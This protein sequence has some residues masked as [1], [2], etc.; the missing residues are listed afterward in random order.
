MSAASATFC[1]LPFSHL[2]VNND[3]TVSPCCVSDARYAADDGR[4]FMV[5]R[6]RLASVWQGTAIQELRAA[7]AGGQK[8]EACRTCWEREDRG[9]DSHRLQQLRNARLSSTVIDPRDPIATP[10]PTFITVRVGSICNLK[11]R[12][13]S[14]GQSTRWVEEASAH[15]GS[16][17]ADGEQQRLWQLGNHVQRRR[18]HRWGED[19]P[20]FWSE[21][22]SAMDH[23]LELQFHGGEPFMVPHQIAAVRRLSQHARAGQVHL[24]YVTNGTHMPSD[25]ITEIFPRFHQVH[26]AFS[27]DGTGPQFEYQRHGADWHTVDANLR[28]CMSAWNTPHGPRGQLTITLT[29]S[30][31]NIMY[32]HQYLP[33]FTEIG[34]PVSLNMVEDRP[35]LDPQNLPWSLRRHLLDILQG[36]PA[37]LLHCISPGGT[38]WSGIC[39]LLRGEPRAESCQPFVDSMRR[40]DTYRGENYAAVF[41]EMARLVGYRA[42]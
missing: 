26:V 21:L 15:L 1:P 33:Y 29:V 25:L 5:D 12:I 3:G 41:P 38:S 18:L 14:P 22:E 20:E 6:D 17:W 7:L 11:C 42:P 23:L 4:A 31:M 34:I 16:D 39:D 37:E 19:S 35:D 2:I 28:R 27:V 9:L 24:H 8:P 40:M 30:A 36:C 10:Q 13:C 32:L